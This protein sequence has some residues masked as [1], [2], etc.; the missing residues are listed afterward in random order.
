MSLKRL[1]IE[2]VL[3]AQR[4]AKANRLVAN[5]D[6]AAAQ[7][8]FHLYPCWTT[9]Q[10]SSSRGVTDPIDRDGN[11]IDTMLSPIRDMK[12]AALA[13]ARPKDCIARLSGTEVKPMV[14]RLETQRRARTV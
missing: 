10:C 4:S 5:V 9:T 12:V 1:G 14:L 3:T 2:S 13:S 8:G 6:S 11:L 7:E